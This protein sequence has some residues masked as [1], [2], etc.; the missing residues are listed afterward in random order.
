VIEVR[1]YDPAWPDRF[2]EL[3]AEYAAALDAAAVPFVSIEHVGST[4][5]PGLAA[6]PVIDIDI[7][8]DLAEVDAAA[9]VLVSLGFEPRGEL[10]IP[11]A[12][13]S[14]N[15]TASPA[16]TRTWSSPVLLRCG[17]IWP[18]ATPCEPTLTSEPSTAT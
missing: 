6:K 17:T 11:N 5:V 4:A 2:E 1:D 18:S 10:G 12:G 7:V 14:G 9:S 16:L 15:L 13:H 8:V 3:R